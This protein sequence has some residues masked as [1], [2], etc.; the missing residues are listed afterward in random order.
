MMRLLSTLT[1][2]LLL[3]CFVDTAAKADLSNA[4]YIQA[5]KE[6]IKGDYAKVVDLLNKYVTDDDK[7]LKS[8]EDILTKIKDVISYCTIQLHPELRGQGLSDGSN[9]KPDLP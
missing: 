5:K 6:Y 1:I 8:N 3:F 7:F 2:I 9:S 4:I